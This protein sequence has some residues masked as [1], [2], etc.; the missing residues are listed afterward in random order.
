[1]KSETEYPDDESHINDMMTEISMGVLA[2][3]FF[4]VGVYLHSKIIITS[5]RDK[6][7][8]WKLDVVNSLVIFFHYANILTMKGITYLVKDLHVYTGSFFCY[9]IKVITFS[10]NTLT[11]GHSLIIAVMKYTMIVHDIKVR[12]FGKDKMK[13]IFLW[14]N[15]FCP[16]YWL[17]F[18]N[19]VRPDFLFV[20]DGISQVNRCLGKSDLMAS[21]DSNKTALKL[22]D[23]CK[24]EIPPNPFSAEYSLYIFRTGICWFH[25]VIVY[26]NVF[27]IIEAFIYCRIFIFMRRLVRSMLIF[28]VIETILMIYSFTNIFMKNFIDIF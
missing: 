9:V 24:F 20:F 12:A 3:S 19:I 8:T 21:D 11:T 18:F 6:Q 1:M 13:K 23:M 25:I 26:C 14:I 2:L 5:K 27:S 10:G 17:L 7:M 22:H 28:N 15:I 16:I 4:I